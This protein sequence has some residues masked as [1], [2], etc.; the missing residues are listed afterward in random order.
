MA[1]TMPPEPT[2]AHK[3]ME[4]AV[5]AER[6]RAHAMEANEADLTADEVRQVLKR[7]R[8]RMGKLAA[9][10]AA[11]RA[12]AVQSQL[13]AEVLEEGRIN[14]LMRRLDHVQQEKG[15]L[16]VELEREEEMVCTE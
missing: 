7:E 14:H 13:E 6:Q 11:L 15:R 10:L 9:D 5:A 8:W 16:I 2:A 3:A 12:T 4:A 1:S